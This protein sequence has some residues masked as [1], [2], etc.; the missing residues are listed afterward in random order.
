MVETMVRLLLISDLMGL[1]HYVGVICYVYKRYHSDAIVLLGN[2]VS[3]SIVRY[4]V[5]QCETRV[6]GV[7]G[8]YD[9]ASLAS[10]LSEVGGLLD[11]KSVDAYD[12][13][14]YGYGLS[15]CI[16]RGVQKADILVTSIPGRRHTC[17]IAGTD[18]VD[19]IAEVVSA[20]VI[21]TGGC[22]KPCQHGTTI[23]PGSARHGFAG[24]LVYSDEKILFR[25]FN[26]SMTPTLQ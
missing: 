13:S 6:Y 14:I 8:R 3:P 1:K 11:C 19:R 9:N 16:P 2:T 20:R 23:S 7:L 26:L 4:F 10:V 24:L 18:I 21:I 5:E 15:G 25:K 17:C 12:V 22:V